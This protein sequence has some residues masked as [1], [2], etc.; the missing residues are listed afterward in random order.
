M[1][2]GMSIVDNINKE[3]VLYGREDVDVDSKMS[4]DVLREYVYGRYQQLQQE[5][6][7]GKSIF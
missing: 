7:S 2:E 4:H 5:L 6:Y 3:R 1:I